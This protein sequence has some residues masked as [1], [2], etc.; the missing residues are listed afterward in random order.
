MRF[1]QLPLGQ[2]FRYQ[3]KIYR[4]TGPLTASEEGVGNSR[5]IMKSA[6]VTPLESAAVV[7]EEKQQFSRREVEAI[8]DR[9]RSE[10]STTMRDHAGPQTSLAVQDVLEVIAAHPLTI[11]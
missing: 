5:L 8:C 11:D 10:L 3:G 1:P 4:K 6:Q 9:F 2:R 7:K